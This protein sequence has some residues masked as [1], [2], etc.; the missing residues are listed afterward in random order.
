MANAFFALTEQYNSDGVIALLAS[1]QAVV[2]YRIAQS[3]EQAAARYLT[4]F[5]A[6]VPTEAPLEQQHSV[7]VRLAEGLLPPS[8]PEELS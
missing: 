2:F 7:A 8:V 5:R 6:A 1:G 3:Y 4:E